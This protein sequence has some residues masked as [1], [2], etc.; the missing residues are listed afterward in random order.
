MT[1]VMQNLSHLF[2]EV[3]SKSLPKE[4]TNE[5]KKFVFTRS[6]ELLG[7]S[8]YMD[9]S[10]VVVPRN[11]FEYYS[12]FIKKE[13]LTLKSLYALEYAFR[14]RI[15]EDKKRELDGRLAHIYISLS[16]ALTQA[17]KLEMYSSSANRD[18][19]KKEILDIFINSSP[20][21]KT[22]ALKDLKASFYSLNSYKTKNFDLS[23]S[24]EILESIANTKLNINDF[25]LDKNNVFIFRQLLMNFFKIE[26][27]F[28]DFKTS[29]L[30][31]KDYIYSRAPALDKIR[32]KIENFTNIVD[33][34][35][36]DSI[37]DKINQI[38]NQKKERF[39][40]L[41]CGI[42]FAPY[43]LSSSIINPK[44]NDRLRDEMII[45]NAL[46]ISSIAHLFI[47]EMLDYAPHF[48]PAYQSTIDDTLDFWLKTEIMKRAALKYEIKPE[49]ITRADKR[50]LDLLIKD[51]PERFNINKI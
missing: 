15:R 50:A 47:H 20:I 5:L 48:S 30:L 12:L 7:N 43:F 14:E 6:S 44:M 28:I 22:L 37:E 18:K 16:F 3:N 36:L 8:S 4:I 26:R 19:V 46:D 29:L 51:H 9:L 23:L 49:L 34:K 39:F 32:F 31:D 10:R 38:S 1:H 13:D 24:C 11:G 33:N 21:Y 27:D 45:Y 25:S 41:L 35:F 2:K 40:K 17:P 42:T